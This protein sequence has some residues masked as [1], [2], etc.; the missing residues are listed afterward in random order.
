VP[1]VWAVGVVRH[2]LVAQTPALA[3]QLG[4]GF[5]AARRA[6]AEQQPTILAAAAARVNLP[7]PV[8]TALF[9]AQ[10][11]ALAPREYGALDAYFTY[12]QRLRLTP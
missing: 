10:T 3:A 5:T 4:E 12:T 8:I 1:L 2:A 11:T 7:E 6:V 9:A